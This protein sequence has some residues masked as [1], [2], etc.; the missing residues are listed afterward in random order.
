MAC[1]FTIV[2]IVRNSLHLKSVLRGN[3]TIDLWCKSIDW[4]LRNTDFKCREVPNGLYKLNYFRNVF[5]G[6]CYNQ[7]LI[8]FIK[9]LK[10]LTVKEFIFSNG[11]K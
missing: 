5:Q 7:K 8:I 2:R 6:F 3:Q 1:N 9:H 11:L 10:K 4:F